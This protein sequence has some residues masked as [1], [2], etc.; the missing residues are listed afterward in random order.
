MRA[1]VGSVGCQR[2]G[3]LGQWADRRVGRRALPHLVPRCLGVDPIYQPGLRHGVGERGRC[4]ATRSVVAEGIAPLPLSA[5]LAPGR[6]LFR[7]GP[8]AQPLSV[9]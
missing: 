5:D 6:Y 1:R 9:G 4:L 3:D 2:G 7:S 8:C